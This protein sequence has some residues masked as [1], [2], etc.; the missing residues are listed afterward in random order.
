MNISDK[1]MLQLG[2]LGGVLLVLLL[3]AALNYPR[4]ITVAPEWTVRVTDP[5]G[6]AIP[7]VSVREEWR[8]AAFDDDLRYQ[9][10]LTDETGVVR[11]ERRTITA[12]RWR[13]W[14]A[15]QRRGANQPCEPQGRVLAFKC[16]HGSTQ[17]LSGAAW[18]HAYDGLGQQVNVTLMLRACAQANAQFGCLP[19]P[20]RGVQACP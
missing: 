14:R 20:A 10:K 19:H 7:L 11:F 2:L 18:E 13:L 12:S 5:A 4:E 6:Q 15:C 9:D 3:L 1:A 17:S 16:G 8:H